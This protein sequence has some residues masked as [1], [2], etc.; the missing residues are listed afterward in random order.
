MTSLRGRTAS[1][2]LCAAAAIVVAGAAVAS[3]D[4]AVDA[5]TQPGGE[6]ADTM[7]IAARSGE[8]FFAV[9]GSD[10]CIRIS[11]YVAA[12]AEFGGGLRPASHDS[13]PFDAA[14]DRGARAREPGS[15]P[16]PVST[17]RWVRGGYTSRSAA[18]TSNLEAQRAP[19]A[20]GQKGYAELG[21]GQFRFAAISASCRRGRTV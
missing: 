16:T 2:S 21:A 6:P 19:L 11:G 7:R 13:G 20:K 8:G 9:S 17:R 15:A 3:G 5:A 1:S 14:L 12:G 10:A 18:T 4:L